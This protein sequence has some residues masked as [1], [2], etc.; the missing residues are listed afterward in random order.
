V[1]ANS[2]FCA[3]AAIIVMVILALPYQL[4]A[5]AKSSGT[6][7]SSTAQWSVQVDKINPGDVALESAFQ[8]AIYENLLD[9]L[10]KTKQ[11]KQVFRSGD[12]NANA[13]DVPN[14]LLLKTTVQ[15][16]TAGS[17]T[18]RAV[19]TVSGATKLNVL[20]QLC[21]RDGKVVLELT[22]EGDVHFFGSN[23]EDQRIN[24]AGSFARGSGI[25]GCGE[26]R[27]IQHCRETTLVAVV[28]APW[29]NRVPFADC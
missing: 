16:Y 13:K 12:R 14:L 27:S 29:H 20:S 3:L 8:V 19:T 22:V 6:N 9:E 18:K 24:V 1:K 21:G 17:E 25:R 11:F 5:E 10:G 28:C 2:K 26:R 4:V 7:K 23:Q 15:K